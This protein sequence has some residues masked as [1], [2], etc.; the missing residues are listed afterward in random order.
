MRVDRG[1]FFLNVV[2]P[3]IVMFLLSLLESIF[4]PSGFLIMIVFFVMIFG[5]PGTLAIFNLKSVLTRGDLSVFRIAIFM[6]SGL[7]LSLGI[8][9]LT[10]GLSTGNLSRPDEETTDVNKMFMRYYLYWSVG[11]YVVGQTYRII[12]HFF[13]K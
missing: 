2:T 6:V 13:R 3:A 10:W 11:F 12:T 4:A 1:L 9:Y 8:G 5:L 7:L